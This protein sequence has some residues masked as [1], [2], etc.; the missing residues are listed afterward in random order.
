M[1][2]RVAAD[3]APITAGGK[4]GVDDLYVSGMERDRIL[5][6]VMVLTLARS[7]EIPIREQL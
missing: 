6:T 4:R 2:S 7:L 1:A 5:P 3:L